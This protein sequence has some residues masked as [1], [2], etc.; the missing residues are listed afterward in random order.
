MNRPVDMTAFT[1]DVMTSAGL[2]QK[3]SAGPFTLQLAWSSCFGLDTAPLL[4]L[5]LTH[6]LQR[7]GKQLVDHHNQMAEKP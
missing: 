5:C 2:S 6:L 4:Q 1:P 3:F 7:W